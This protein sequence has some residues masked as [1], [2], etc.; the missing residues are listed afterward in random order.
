MLIS[1]IKSQCLA[2]P[3]LSASLLYPIAS[4]LLFHCFLE[5]RHCRWNDAQVP[6]LPSLSGNKL[7]RYQG[8]GD[9]Q[10]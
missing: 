8:V 5:S 7:E 3:A 9:M 1:T 4:F 2:E 6:F 10:A